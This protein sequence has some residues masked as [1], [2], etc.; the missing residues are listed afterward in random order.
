MEKGDS[1]S[2]GHRNALSSIL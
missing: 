1:V 2:E